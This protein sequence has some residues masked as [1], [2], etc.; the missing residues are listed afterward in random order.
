M[1]R[2]LTLVLTVLCVSPAFARGGGH[3]G[4]HASGHAFGH[5]EGAGHS[6]IHE[7]ESPR[8]SS[9]VWSWWWFSHPAQSCDKTKINNCR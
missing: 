6:A 4:G 5:S 7:T 8:S 9:A 3:G 1:M 2:K